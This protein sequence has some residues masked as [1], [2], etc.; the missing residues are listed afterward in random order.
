MHCQ[1][2]LA[3]IPAGADEPCLRWA[4]PWHM[5]HFGS[6]SRWAMM[7][8]GRGLG[9]APCPGL[10]SSESNRGHL[11]PQVNVISS[12]TSPGAIARDH[13]CDGLGVYTPRP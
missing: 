9:D 11:K 8:A 2:V 4:G 13:K 5:H 7:L 1:A 3:D 10:D 6:W 12:W